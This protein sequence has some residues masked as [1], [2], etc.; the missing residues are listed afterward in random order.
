MARIGSKG[1]VFQMFETRLGILVQT[2][3]WETSKHGQRG[4]YYLAEENSRGA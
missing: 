2:L 1:D 4:E 3:I